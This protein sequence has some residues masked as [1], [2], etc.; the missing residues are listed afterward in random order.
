MVGCCCCRAKQ[1]GYRIPVAI[2][3]LPFGAVR[4]WLAI[5]I[6]FESAEVAV[7]AG[8]ASAVAHKL[9]AVRPCLLESATNLD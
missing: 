2:Y 7:D 4:S 1:Y 9:E 5:L 6:G 8:S 3:R